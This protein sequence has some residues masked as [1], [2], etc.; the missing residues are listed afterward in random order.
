MQV[1]FLVYHVVGDMI[2]NIHGG[3]WN[4]ATFYHE[5]CVAPIVVSASIVYQYDFGVTN[6]PRRSLSGHL[7]YGDRRPRGCKQISA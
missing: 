6:P 1:E 3:P 7:S 2:P 4:G 5:A